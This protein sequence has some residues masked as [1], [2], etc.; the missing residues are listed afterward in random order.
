MTHRFT[1]GETQE[2]TF[3]IDLKGTTVGVAVTVFPPEFIKDALEGQILAAARKQVATE[4]DG[5]VTEDRA[6]TLPSPEDSQIQ[7]NGRQVVVESE[8]M[9]MVSRN[10]WILCRGTLYRILQSGSLE[11]TA[12]PDFDRMASSFQLLQSSPPPQPEAP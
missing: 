1:V 3:L 6:L 2:H 11:S 8:S 4:I 10:R 9:H 12:A 7:L 5:T